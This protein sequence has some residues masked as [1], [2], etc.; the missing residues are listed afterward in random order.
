MVHLWVFGFWNWN[1]KGIWVP[2]VS[3]FEMPNHNIC[4]D[5]YAFVNLV[6][7]IYDL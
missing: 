2:F 4:F 5:T 3:L 7:F 6:H 1:I